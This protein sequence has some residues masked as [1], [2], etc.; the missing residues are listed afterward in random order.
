MD[1]LDWRPVVQYVRIAQQHYALVSHDAGSPH[2]DGILSRNFG[3]DVNDPRQLNYLIQGIGI[4]AQA[5]TQVALMTPRAPGF[6]GLD[7]GQAECLASSVLQTSVILT[8]H[9]AEHLPAEVRNGRRKRERISGPPI[10]PT[11]L[12]WSALVPAP[13]QVERHEAWLRAVASGATPGLLAALDQDEAML[14]ESLNQGL[15]TYMSAVAQVMIA[16]LAT[17]DLEPNEVPT[18][19]ALRFRDVYLVA[20]YSNLP[21][22][23]RRL[24][25]A[26]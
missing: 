1:K 21:S 14:R 18:E 20:I 11:T 24:A 2:I 10:D 4:F 17:A 22:E 26:T 13:D 9:L 6:Y 23:Y 8:V 15:I 3:I 19:G 5:L 25:E 16:L 12:K 7:Q